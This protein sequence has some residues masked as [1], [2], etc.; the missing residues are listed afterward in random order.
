MNC[1]NCGAPL[2][3]AQ[4]GRYFYCEYCSTLC[5]P[6]TDAPDGVVVVGDLKE[7]VHCPL[8]DVD[9]VEAM[10]EG[11]SVLHCPRCRGVLADQ[12]S[13]LNI[14]KYRRARASG[15]PD[16]PRPLDQ[17]DLQR[18]IYCPTC[19]QQMDTHPYYGPGNFVI[20]TCVRCALLW[21]DCGEIDIMT[22]AP[23]RDRRAGM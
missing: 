6:E 16:R 5:F 9:L 3:L 12:D 19:G 7:D 15:A 11:V 4:G 21:L 8:C 1:K 18:Q 13:F 23:G 17:E 14:V 2:K 20:D 10:V 22:N